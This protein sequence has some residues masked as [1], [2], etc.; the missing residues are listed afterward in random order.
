[1]PLGLFKGERTYDLT[2]V[3]EGLVRFKM[4]EEYSGPMLSMIWSTIPD[5][6]PSFDEFA[7]S[8]KKAAEKE[9]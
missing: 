7:R 2:P 3:S 4:R 6:G 8:L 9:S 5:L 1:M